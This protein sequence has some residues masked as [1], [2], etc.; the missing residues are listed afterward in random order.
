MRRK[1]LVHQDVTFKTCPGG[2]IHS[3]G[4]R[5]RIRGPNGPLPSPRGEKL[6]LKTLENV[7][8]FVFDVRGWNQVSRPQDEAQGRK[9]CVE[10]EFEVR[11][12]GF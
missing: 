7:Q 10:S 8:N 5:I 9:F 2:Y 6:G 12:L 11:K 4:H 3:L 1:S